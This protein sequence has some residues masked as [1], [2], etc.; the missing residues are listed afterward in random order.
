MI[1]F[2]LFRDTK[3]YKTSFIRSLLIEVPMLSQA[4]EQTCICMPR[5][6]ISPNKCKERKKDTKKHLILIRLH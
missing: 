1:L 2:Y 6:W 4:S 5:M 3:I